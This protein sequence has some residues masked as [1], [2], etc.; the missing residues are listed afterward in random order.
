MPCCT[1]GK[2]VSACAVHLGAGG[3]FGSGIRCSYELGRGHNGYNEQ[4]T[5]AHDDQ[6]L[7]LLLLGLASSGG[8]D[9]LTHEVGAEPYRSIRQVQ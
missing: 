7:F 6:S 2:Q 4:L 9:A 1:N 8:R 5:V 3:S